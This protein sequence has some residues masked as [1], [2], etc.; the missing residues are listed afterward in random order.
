MKKVNADAVRI[1]FT[2]HLQEA[3][4]RWG[5]ETLPV[6]GGYSVPVVAPDG[7]E[8]YVT[9]SIVVRGKNREGVEYD[10]YDDSAMYLEEQHEKTEFAKAKAQEKARKEALREEK[11]A[12]KERAKALQPTPE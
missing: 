4:E 11:K 9:V 3:L 8:G 10:G 2:N 7:E 6:E 1:N 5:Y 12:E